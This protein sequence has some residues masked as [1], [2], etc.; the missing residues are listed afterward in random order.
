MEGAQPQ[1]GGAP[2]CRGGGLPRR[3][4]R[5]L[6]G[7]DGGG[8]LFF[9]RTNFFIF[10]YIQMPYLRKRRMN[11]RRKIIKRRIPRRGGVKVLN[12]LQ[13]FPS[14]QIV[15]MKYSQAVQ[16]NAATGYN[17]L[18]N[19]NSIFDPDRTGT[20]HQ[21]YGH[22]TLQSLYNRYRVISCSY[23]VQA[24][25]GSFPIRFSTIPTNTGTT[26]STIAEVA[27]NPRSRFSIQIPGG[28]TQKLV[29]KVYLP[30]LMGRSKTLYMADDR[31]QAEFGSNPQELG[32]LTLTALG[33]QETGV[34]VNW[35]VTLEYTVEVFDPKHLGQS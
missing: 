35:S 9:V 7:P 22:D 26:F 25:S 15:K 16:T 14:R 32:T 34:D 6:K 5:N 33:L 23:V 30:S 24:Y 10:H 17:W 31:Y 2:A 3:H 21:P 8:R 12:S 13:P 4:D 1:V 11:K 29:G 18:F 28:S 19:L 27:E 20:G